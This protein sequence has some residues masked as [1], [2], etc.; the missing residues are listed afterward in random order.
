MRNRR[1]YRRNSHY[2]RSFITGIITTLIFFCVTIGLIA[3]FGKSIILTGNNSLNFTPTLSLA[4]QNLPTI[5]ISPT[6]KLDPTPSPTILTPIP[7]I[8]LATPTIEPTIPIVSTT[9]V[10][11]CA[12]QTE[13]A[14]PTFTGNS[15]IIAD[16]NTKQTLLSYRPELQIYPASTIKLLTAMVGLDLSK[17][18]ELLTLSEAVFQNITSDIACSGV[19]VGTTYPLEVWLNLLLVRSFGDAANT[20]AE[21]TA[22]SIEQFIDKMNQKIEQLGLTNTVVDNAVGLDIGNGFSNIHSTAKDMLTIALESLQYP[23]IKEIIA[24]PTYLIP[25]TNT[26]PETLIPNSHPFL[27]PL[28]SYSSPYFTT[29]GGKTGTTSA[30]GNCLITIVKGADTHTYICVYFG[31]KTR[32]TMAKEIIELLEYVIESRTNLN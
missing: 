14:P 9:P 24:K 19:P 5:P 1:N 7:T 4:P 16:F 2:L 30:A 8:P 32:D 29:I 25:A 31:G 6:K 12:F 17:P 10:V 27:S 3:V 20:I 28:E 23:L 13:K 26:T 15:Y 18:S 22:G 21:E 11:Y